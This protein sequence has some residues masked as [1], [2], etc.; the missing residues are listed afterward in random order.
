M[1]DSD[2]ASA[3]MMSMLEQDG[4][5]KRGRRIILMIYMRALDQSNEVDALRPLVVC[6]H[7]QRQLPHD[8]Q[9]ASYRHAWS[10]H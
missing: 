2:E 5:A 7:L 9:Q 8:N 3:T 1:N 6:H 10:L 4:E